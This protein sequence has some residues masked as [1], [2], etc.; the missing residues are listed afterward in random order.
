M[1]VGLH[2]ITIFLYFCSK[3]NNDFRLSRTNLIYN[4]KIVRVNFSSYEHPRK[5]FLAARASMDY[6]II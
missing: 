2:T 4:E 5:L 6:L 3:T 1:F